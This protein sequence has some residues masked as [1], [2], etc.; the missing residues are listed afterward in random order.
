MNSNV[1]LHD[2]IEHINK[3]KIIEFVYENLILVYRNIILID[4]ISYVR[5][6][7]EIAHA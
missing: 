5:G 7:K 6:Y 4:L 3:G 1:S 2:F